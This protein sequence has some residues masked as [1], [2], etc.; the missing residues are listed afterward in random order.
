MIKKYNN[1]LNIGSVLDLGCGTGLVGQKIRTFS[2]NIDGID[3]SQKMLSLAK[4]KKVYDNLIKDNILNFLSTSILKYDYYLSADVFI[5]IGDLTD[6]FSLIKN[7][8]KRGGNLVFSTEHYDGEGYFLEQS[9][10]Y[11]HSKKYIE[12]LCNKFKFE[13]INFK[14]HVLRKNKNKNINGGLYFLKF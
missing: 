11:S 8:S 4:K 13:L 2:K 12:Q 3:I 14:S 1:S 7:K 6:V 9:G 5:Y 10:R